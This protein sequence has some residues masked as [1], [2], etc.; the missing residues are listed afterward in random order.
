MFKRIDILKLSKKIKWIFCF[1]LCLFFFAFQTVSGQNLLLENK[2]QLPN[3]VKYQKV[4]TNG[5]LYYRDQGFTTLLRNNAQYDSLWKHYHFYK[6]LNKEFKVN[7]H[8]F[9]VNFENANLSD[10]E[11]K[12]A[13]VTNYNFFKGNDAAQWASNVKAYHEIIYHNIYNSVNLQIQNYGNDVKHNYILKPNANAENIKLRYSFINKMELMNSQLVIHTS[14]G[15]VVEQKPIAFQMI[16]GDSVFVDCK[17]ILKKDKSD[18]LVSFG[19]GNYNKNYDLIIDP[20]LVFATYS[21]SKGDNFGFTATHDSRAHLYSA[22]IVDGAQG[23]FPVTTG[24]FQTIYGGSSSTG[25]APANLKCDIGINKYDSA[26]TTLLYSTYLGGNDDEYPHSLVVDNS[27]NLLVM[28]TTYSRNFPLDSLGYDTSFNGNTDIFVVKL[29]K[30][31][32]KLLAGTY[33]GGND[34]DGLNTRSLR[35]NYADDFRGDIVVDSADNIYVASTTYSNNFPQ[36]KAFQAFKGSTQEGC[37]FSFEKTLKIIRFSTFVGGNNDDACYS[38]RLF[39]SFVYIGG[40]TASGTMNFNLNGAKNTYGG[41]IDGFILKLKNTGEFRNSS[42]FGTN[43]YDQVHFLDI[44]DNGQVY[45]AGQTEGLVTRTPGTYGVDNTSQFIIRMSPNLA[46]VN[47]STTFGNRLNNPEISPS[48]FLV[49]KCENIYFSGWGSPITDGTLHR[50]TTDKLPITSGAVQSTTDKSDF[51]LLVLNKNAKSLLYA[52]YFGGNKTED[53]VDG[54]TSRFDKKGVVYQAVCA[55]CPDGGGNQD[56]PVT[57][58]APFTSNPSPRCSNA[59]FKIDF[60]ITFLVDAKFVAN[61]TKGCSPL[62]VTFTNQSKKARQ[63]VW[64]FGDGTKDT[65]R[66]PVHIF[67][68]KG[69]YMVKLKSIDSFSCNVFEMDSTEIEVLESPTADFKFEGDACNSKVKFTNLSSNYKNPEW[70]F[71]DSLNTITR[72]ENPTHTYQKDGRFTVLLKVEHPTSGCID[73]QTVVIPIFSD[74]SKSLKIPNVFTPNTDN[75]ND[76]YTI[77]GVDPSCDDVKCW[78]YDRWGLLIFEGKLLEKCWNGRLNNTGA[79]MPD[80]V[81]YYLMTI[82]RKNAKDGNKTIKVNGVIHLIKGG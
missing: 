23:A 28:G 82:E 14:V 2:G 68:K 53:H 62:K 47:L 7:F 35:Y 65:A 79:L 39:D 37:V 9:D 58:G 51:Y 49:D 74:P 6:R 5:F 44:D 19:L 72:E 77:E 8:R 46:N 81:Y 76:C 48:A 63:Q 13:D 25:R 12:Y 42:Y 17:Y 30:I 4:L 69:K 78:I 29:S 70:N 60:Q 18:Y 16:N 52:T 50:L 61:P 11:K 56:F 41:K 36:K 54:G 66:N 21:G 24:A 20:I 64:D 31:G 3:I 1:F 80:G 10:I 59:S 55:S 32:D 27:D 22:G 33:I 71:G 34:F 15:K 38:I 26:G 73:T 45:A 40:G 57:S 75:I 67:T 43:E